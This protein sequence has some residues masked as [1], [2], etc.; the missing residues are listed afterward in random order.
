MTVNDH[1]WDVSPGDAIPCTLHD[2]HGLYNNTDE[3][4]SIFVFSASME[5]NKFDAK[6]WGEDLSD[7]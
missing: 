3:D 1:T 7:R 4:L 5:K 2:S 6:D